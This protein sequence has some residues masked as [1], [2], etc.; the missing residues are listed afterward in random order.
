MKLKPQPWARLDYQ[1]WDQLRVKLGLKLLDEFGDQI[2]DQLWD[3][4][5]D[6]LGKL[7]DLLRQ[8]EDDET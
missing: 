7:W 5:G 1:F 4:L 8:M 6:R 2:W 3:Q